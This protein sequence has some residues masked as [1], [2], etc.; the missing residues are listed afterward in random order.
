MEYC[1]MSRHYFFS[2]KKC[3]ESACT[4]CHPPRC[5]P[6]DFEQLHRLSD[7]VPGEDLHYKSFEELYGKQTTEDHR[8][9]LKNAKIK[10][11]GKMKTTKV[12]HTMPFCPS[13]TRAKNVGVTVNCIE[14]EK[15][16]LLFSAKKLSEKDK[17][18]L[19]EFLDT[20]FYICSMSFRNTYDLAMTIPRKKPDIQDDTVNEMDEKDDCNE[21]EH[22][23]EDSDSDSDEESDNAEEKSDNV[24]KESDNMKDSIYELFSRVYVNDSWSFLSQVERPYSSLNTYPAA[25]IVSESLDVLSII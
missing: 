12:K 9:S 19:R 23:R 25:C 11:K 2:I 21:N 18:M 8:P 4:I 10:I 16:R 5:L 6:E 20:I 24:K 14:C 15:P 13:A 7:L 3:D 22:E 1:C 17:M